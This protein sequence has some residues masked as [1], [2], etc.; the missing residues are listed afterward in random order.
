M[1]ALKVA[2]GVMLIWWGYMILLVLSVR[3][4]AWALP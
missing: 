4:L 1:R 2:G 3:F